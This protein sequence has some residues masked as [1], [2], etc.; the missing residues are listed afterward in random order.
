MVAGLSRSDFQAISSHRWAWIIEAQSRCPKILRG[1][2][3]PPGIPIDAAIQPLA[4]LPLFFKLG[5]RRVLLVGG[6][7]GAAWKAELLAAAGAKIVVIAAEPGERM[8][9]IVAAA[10]ASAALIERSWMPDDLKGAALAI[11]DLETRE[12]ALA[13]QAAAR[14]S[15]VPVNLVDR[16]EFCDFQFGSIV[17]RSPLV[18]GISTDGAAPVF[19][20]A[21]RARIET[22]LPAGFARWA[23]AA[24]DWRPAVQARALPFR[25]RRDFWESFTALALSRPN[26]A[27]SQDDQRN[28]LS[29]ADDS[30]PA[31][32]TG[33]VLLVGAGPGDPELLTLRAGACA[34]IRRCRDV[35]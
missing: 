32:T 17:N 7:D 12:D 18:V 5:G 25:A 9:I 35:R 11:A 33:R 20:Q 13:F 6:S 14:A 10:G 31:Q 3:R 27:P 21:V 22:L 26:D 1:G 19:G 30:V 34:A 4:T 16:P 2:S 23:Q 8:R 28:L 24:R 29:R 15:G